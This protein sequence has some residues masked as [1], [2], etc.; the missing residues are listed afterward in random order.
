MF[1]HK[2]PAPCRQK[3]QASWRSIR[4]SFMEEWLKRWFCLLVLNVRYLPCSGRVFACVRFSI[5]TFFLIFFFPFHCFLGI[6]PSVSLLG[7]SVS[8]FTSVTWSCSDDAV[9]LVLVE[10]AFCI[11]GTEATSALSWGNHREVSIYGYKGYCSVSMFMLV[12]SHDLSASCLNLNDIDRR[13]DRSLSVAAIWAYFSK[14]SL[15]KDF[16]RFMAGRPQDLHKG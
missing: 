12:S 14:S 11:L 3:L 16:L 1:G 10:D 9:A 2:W 8:D 15:D 13:I 7:T 6:S 4:K 5:L